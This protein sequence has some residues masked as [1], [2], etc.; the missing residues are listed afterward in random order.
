[1]TTN[2]KSMIG[3]LI[4]LGSLFHTII[5]YLLRYIFVFRRFT[6]SLLLLLG[7]TCCYA[8]YDPSFAHYF[9][10]E[11]TF[12]PASVGKQAKINVTAAYANDMAGFE[13]NPKTMLF[14]ADMPFYALKNY[15][16][17]GLQ[18]V[19][20]QIGLFTHQKLS[21]QY[22]FKR[23][24]FKGMLS[25][26]LQGGL[27]SESFDGSK[28]DANDS[29]DP[30]LATSKVDGNG[31]D[32]GAGLYYTHGAWYVGVSALHLTS[33]KIDLGERNEI[34]IDPIYYLTG[35]YNI[36][37]KNPFLLIKPSALLRYDGATWRG[38][39]NCRLVYTHEK[40]MMYGGVTYSPTNSVTFM[41]GG[42]FH[43]IILGYSY[44]M[45]TSTLSPGDGSHELFVGYQADINLVKK[46]RNK[47]KSVRIL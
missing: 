30:A 18:F 4:D 2:I 40:K 39:A 29:N 22:A 41:V 12:N 31:F 17:V 46:G 45:Y 10:L 35:G 9:D 19:N 1:M 11:P 16:G 38:D 47:H 43:G 44:E 15:H 13:N 28:V 32:V 6:I 14:S 36:K 21:V 26:G 5:S 8:Q 34:Q 20:D 42:S 24:L 7:V 27:L 33:P 25:I 3:L 23:R 37:L